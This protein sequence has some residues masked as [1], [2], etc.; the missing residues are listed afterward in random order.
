M[1]IM[2]K[3]IFLAL[4]FL[5]FWQVTL[6]E[7]DTELDLELGQHDMD[8]INPELGSGLLER[9]IVSNLTIGKSA[10][11]ILDMADDIAE[12]LNDAILCGPDAVY[13]MVDV[14]IPIGLA[15]DSIAKACNLTGA[16][17]AELSRALPPGMNGG[18]PGGGPGIPVSP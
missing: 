17:L 16:T 14:G 7:S 18:G 9:E 13:A 1:G 3:N 11:E 6:A 2:I 5:F 4:F 8:D 10:D 12:A 15:L